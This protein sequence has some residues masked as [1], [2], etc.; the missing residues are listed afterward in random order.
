[1][2]FLKYLNP[3][4]CVYAHTILSSY[5][6]PS[7]AANLGENRTAPPSPS[8]RQASTSH[9][10]YKI[11]SSLVLFFLSLL[12]KKPPLIFTLLSS[13]LTELRRG[14]WGED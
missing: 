5:F 2:Y 1:M 14:K 3:F 11:A 7:S 12:Q 13:N 6:L 9:C 10:E 8:K 4:S